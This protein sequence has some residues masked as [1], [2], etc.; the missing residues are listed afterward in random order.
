MRTYYMALDEPRSNPPTVDTDWEK[1]PAG[2]KKKAARAKMAPLAQ[3]W[4][5]PD[6][7][8]PLLRGCVP[9]QGDWTVML[10]CTHNMHMLLLQALL[11]RVLAQRMIFQRFRVA[12]RVLLS[13]RKPRK[14]GC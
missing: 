8:W 7:W 10:S 3:V 14:F 13:P 1:G 9:I 11:E 4:V 12:K 2:W 6:R 5:G